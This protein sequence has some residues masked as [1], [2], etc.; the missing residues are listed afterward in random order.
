MYIFAKF[1]PEHIFLQNR[2]KLNIKKF[3]AFDQ[4]LASV[5]LF[6]RQRL[7]IHTVQ[8]QTR[9]GRQAASK[10]KGAHALVFSSLLI[11]RHLEHTGI[12]ASGYFRPAKRISRERFFCDMYGQFSPFPRLFKNFCGLL[13]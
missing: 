3:H 9:K 2:D 10:S 6:T 12:Q 11:N 5:L 4:Q 8:H 7:K 1:V 13:F